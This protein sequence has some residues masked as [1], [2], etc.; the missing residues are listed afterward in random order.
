LI[1]LIVGVLI[2]ILNHK[3]KKPLNNPDVIDTQGVLFT[4]FVAGLLGGIYSSCL[5]AVGL[6]GPTIATSV[7]TVINVAGLAWSPLGRDRF[8]QGGF[9]I[10]GT[11]IALGIGALSAVAVGILTYLTAEFGSNEVF[12]DTTF[13][14]IND[15]PNEPGL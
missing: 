15:A 4:F 12:N 3:L 1:G 13:A 2:T 10:A 8:S 14:Q 11:F 5:A 7:S 6:Y 9:Q